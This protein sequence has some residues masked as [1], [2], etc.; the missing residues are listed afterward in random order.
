VTQPSHRGLLAVF[1]STLFQLV[2]IFMLSPL[3]LLMLKQAGVS[4]TVAGLF[5]AT[6]WLG[7]F[8]MTP[9]ASGLV[10]RLGRR[11]ALW[12]ASGLP[13]LTVCGFLFTRSLSV[14]FA[15]ELLASMAGGL[16]WVLA[17]SF[18]AEFAP[19]AQR[20]RLIGAYATLIGL[21]MVIGPALVAWMGIDSPHGLWTVLAMLVLGLSWTL[22]IPRTPVA[23]DAESASVGLRGLWHA[24]A[25]YPVVMLAGFVAGFFE[26]G[27]GSVLPLYGLSVGLAAGAAALLLS[28][29]GTGG[30]VFAIPAGMLADRFADPARGRRRLMLWLLGLLVVASAGGF[31]VPAWP[32]LVWPIALVWGAAGGTLYTLTMLDIG[33]RERGITLVNS[34]SVL[35]LTYTLGAL[36]ASSSAGAL[37][38]WSPALVFPGIVL[39]VALAGWG[40]LWRSGRSEGTD[41]QFHDGGGVGHSQP[42]GDSA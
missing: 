41:L 31:A 23:H 36:V 39:S 24:I 33:S 2:G 27:L 25:A 13:L 29:S 3:L 21:T 6:T 15:L 22:L 20:G 18:I 7:I 17:E 5:A 9:F 1:G 37:L 28:V 42:D 16:R 4:N 38:D 11:R 34:T 10:R 40:V 12:L 32:A 19:E 35:V 14:W 8:T 30:T 26:L